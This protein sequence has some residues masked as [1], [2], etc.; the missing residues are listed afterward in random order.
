MEPQKSVDMI[1]WHSMQLEEVF[2]SLHSG[3][4]GLSKDA[5]ASSKAEHG[6]NALPKQ[7]SK[8]ALSVFL[9]QLKG[10]MAA[11]L[12]VAAG[13]S[14]I[15]KEW[16]DVAVIGIALAI[17]VGLGFIEEFKADRA[18]SALKNYLPASVRVRRAGQIVSIPAEEVVPGDIMI[19]S[20]GSKVTADARLIKIE[21]LEVGESALTGESAPIKKSLEVIKKGTAPSSRTNSV[22]A[23]TTVL[24]GS[25]EAIVTETGVHTQLGKIADQVART[26]ESETPL[27][28]S[29]R[30]MAAVITGAI[31]FI[32]VIIFSVGL[33]KG[34]EVAEMFRTSI[35]L[36]VAAIPEGLVVT[37]TAILAIGMQ[38]ILKQK[39]LVRKLVAAETLGSVSV[40][41]MDKTGT[42]TEGKMKVSEV[43]VGKRTFNAD[44]FKNLGSGGDLVRALVSTSSATK[45]KD[46]ETGE[47]VFTGTYTEVAIMEFL[48]AAHLTDDDTI[49]RDGFLPFDSKYKFAAATVDDQ[50]FVV[51]APDILLDRADISDEAMRFFRK[52]LEEMAEKGL[53]IIGA[54]S[55]SSRAGQLSQSSIKDLSIIGFIGLTDPIREETAEVIQ[56]ARTAGIRPIMITGDHPKTAISIATQAGI[57]TAEDLCITGKDL[58][59]MDDK[60]LFAKIDSISIFARVMPAHKSR[61]VD[62]LQTK[63]HS[64]AMM[65]DGVNDSPALKSADI[66]I[67]VGS[68]TEVA[69]QA[70]DMVI[71]DSRLGTIVNAIKEGRVIFDN[72]RKVTTFLLTDSFREMILIAGALL[73]GLPTPILAAQILWIN[74]VTDGFPGAVLA[75]EPAESDVMTRAPRK[76]SEP[77]ING[78][79]RWIIIGVALITDIALFAIYTGFINA[80]MQLTTAQTFIFLAI[81]I[82]SLVHIFSIRKL[83]TT[84]FKENIFENKMLL[85]GVG[86]GALLLAVPMLIPQ[87]RSAMHLELLSVELWA[88]LAG[89]AVVH[90]LLVECIKFAFRA[91][92]RRANAISASA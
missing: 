10:P 48:S 78:E 55:T 11:V 21:S 77:I 47:M 6:K 31:L 41:C 29:M 22:F 63:G 87:I 46:Q 43:R 57:T 65:G 53:R 86:V 71:L 8:T 38:R 88:V 72:I 84:M 58:D 44:E 34:V 56:T 42:L 7:R 20:A 76:R 89:F 25:A 81:G 49:K 37:M 91:K 45:E 1:P 14:T 90:V 59:E 40:I 82:S 5:I 17:N 50:L 33:I 9:S 13:A 39:A 12:L 69:K 67:A 28:A 85:G 35:A 75:F 74:I 30:K 15:I 66:G 79:L 27:Q 54:A 16:V 68:G 18:L 62:A 61:I 32:V 70:S 83:R 52:E 51:G 26:E 24:S 19:L 73:F 36:L 80:G 92:S 2:E 60:E 64:V 3:T 23:G 4:Q